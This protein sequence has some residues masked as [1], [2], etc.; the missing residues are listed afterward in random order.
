[1]FEQL[2][3][4]QLWA[5]AQI[6]GSLSWPISFMAVSSL[7]VFM[8]LSEPSLFIIWILGF[9]MGG[10]TALSSSLFIRHQ[11]SAPWKWV[12][13]NTF[14]IPLSLTVASLIYPFTASPFGFATAGLCSG[15]I[16]GI[17]QSLA[18]K[19]EYSKV[20]PLISGALGWALAFLFGYLLVVQDPTVT[21]ALM[22]NDF[23]RALLLGWGSS[24]P[25]L[26]IMLIGL[27]PLSKDKTTSGSGITY[28]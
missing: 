5:M 1:M 2:K 6:V 22:P 13:A 17:A 28:N 7:G 21:V 24:G 18:I 9:V 23:F 16:A 10:I 19:R 12:T 20:A 26:L 27:S 11:I 8:D 25:V 4:F 14:G 15:L 3:G